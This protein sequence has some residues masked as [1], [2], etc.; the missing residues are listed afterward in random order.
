MYILSKPYTNA[1]FISNI[2]RQSSSAIYKGSLHQQYTKAVFIRHV[3]A[4]FIS[5]ISSAIYECCFLSTLRT[6]HVGTKAII[7]L[8]HYRRQ[9]LCLYAHLTDVAH[10]SRQ[11]CL[12]R[13]KLLMVECFNNCAASFAHFRQAINGCSSVFL[14]FF[15]KIIYRYRNPAIMFPLSSSSMLN[16]LYT[17]KYYVK[18]TL[19]LIT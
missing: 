9:P 18:F 6:M 3:K 13:R 8:V 1:V 11:S 19:H 7:I 10:I 12:G 4:V 16:M 17:V 15:G 2:Q 5:H 14:F